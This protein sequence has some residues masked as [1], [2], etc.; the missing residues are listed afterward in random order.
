MVIFYRSSW[1]VAKKNNSPPLCPRLRVGF[2][3]HFTDTLQDLVPFKTNV[4]HVV[5]VNSLLNET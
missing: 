4:L 3:E 5:V 1:G 2:L